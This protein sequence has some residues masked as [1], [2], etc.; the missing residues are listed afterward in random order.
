MQAAG[1][2]KAPVVSPSYGPYRL[3]HQSPGQDVP[4]AVIA[5][6]LLEGQPVLSDW[7][8]GPRHKKGIRLCYKPR[9]KTTLGKVIAPR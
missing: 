1:G 6:Q 7:T 9:H 5:A 8:Q 2:E 4:R 3:Q